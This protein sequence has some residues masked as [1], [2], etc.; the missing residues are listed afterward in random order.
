MKTFQIVRAQPI[1]VRVQAKTYNEALELAG[2]HL[3]D[4][5][6]EAASSSDIITYTGDGIDIEEHV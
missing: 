5:L 3:D 6:S 2:Q 4:F 1:L